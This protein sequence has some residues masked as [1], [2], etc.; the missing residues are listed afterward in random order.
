MLHEK[1]N[2]DT[3]KRK[4]KTKFYNTQEWEVNICNKVTLDAIILIENLK[5]KKWFYLIYSTY[6]CK[7][8]KKKFK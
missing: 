8:K 1:N 5:K 6:A 3:T 2:F 7:K 4:I